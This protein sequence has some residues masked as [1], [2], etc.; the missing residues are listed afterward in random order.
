MIFFNIFGAKFMKNYTVFFVFVLTFFT[1]LSFAGVNSTDPNLQRFFFVTGFFSNSEL[2][3]QNLIQNNTG[4]NNSCGPT[5]LLFI[6]NHFSIQN[7]GNP[8]SFTSNVNS[9]R[10]ALKRLYD[11]IGQSDNT[12]THIDTLRQI[13]EVRWGWTKVFRRSGNSSIDQNVN[14]LIQDLK[15][16]IPAMVVL[17]KNTSSNPFSV[18]HIVIVYAYQMQPD[19]YGRTAGDPNNDRKSDRIYFYDPYYGGNKFFTR[20]EI[21]VHVNLTNF[22]Y[23]RVAP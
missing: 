7:S 5:S 13:P 21:S 3:K 1:H 4:K 20:G 19:S 12:I 15:S 8:P 6:N 16:D 9:A 22:A 10:D 23:L 14:Y 2:V 18:D 11:F 17:K